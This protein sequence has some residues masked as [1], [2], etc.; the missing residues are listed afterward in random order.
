MKKFQMSMSIKSKLTAATCMLLVAFFMVVSS[1]YAW[2]TLSTAPEVTGI[3]TNI[4]ANG[5]LEMA[6]LYGE[7]TTTLTDL[8]RAV[9]TGTST[10]G[11]VTEANMTWGNLVD[12]S[13][14]S[15]GLGNIALL[16]S[17]LTPTSG[18][19]GY[20]LPEKGMIATPVY[21]A[22]GRISS[23]SNTSMTALYTAVDGGGSFDKEGYGVRGLGTSSSMTPQ[24]ADYNAAKATLKSSIASASALANKALQSYGDDLSLILIDKANGAPSNIEGLGEMIRM[25]TN[26][27]TGGNGKGVVAYLDDAVTALGRMAVAKQLEATTGYNALV[28]TSVTATAGSMTIKYTV[29]GGT[30]QTMTSDVTGALATFISLKTEIANSLS[31][32]ATAYGEVKPDADGKVKWDNGDGTGTTY[33][34]QAGNEGHKFIDPDGIT[35]AG[36]ASKDLGTDDAGTLAGY[37]ATG[38]PV[39]FTA[40]TFVDIANATDKALGTSVSMLVTVGTIVTNMPMTAIISIKKTGDAV[41]LVTF[42]NA[43]AEPATGNNASLVLTEL[44]GYVLDLA[45]R[46]NAGGSN[47]LLQT[48]PENRIYAGYQNPDENTDV[49]GGGATMTFTTA[50]P[51]VFTTSDVLNLMKA[52]RVVFTDEGNKILAIGAVQQD[53]E[54]KGYIKADASSATADN[55]AY[56]D[57]NDPNTVVADIYLYD[58]VI[59]TKTAENDGNGVAEGVLKLNG[60]KMTGEGNNATYDAKITALEKNTAKAV[61]ALVYLDGDI[62]DNSMV[63]SSGESM[64][65]KVNLQFASDATLTPMEYSPLMGE[66]T[67][68]EHT[69]EENGTVCTKCKADKNHTTHTYSTDWSS[70]G[71]NHWHASTCKNGNLNCNVKTDVAAHDTTGTDGACSV[72][73]YKAVAHEHT[74]KADWSSDATNHWHAAT[75]NEAGQ[76][77]ANQKDSIA[78]H[79]DL[80]TDDDTLC[81]VCEYDMGENANNL[82]ESTEPEN[83]GEENA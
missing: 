53:A 38:I 45:F 71:T 47:L 30:E 32:A 63:A 17:R 10:A 77:C 58:Y 62:V 49:Q 37:V 74:Y 21:G 5:N 19:D 66:Q 82:T 56:I 54:F 72:C 43:I 23:F 59:G 36:I 52:I 61:S 78:A 22:D 2:F 25:L 68:C 6:L 8:A 40:G 33:V 55:G 7:G 9:T 1:S 67:A 24:Q 69:Y 31:A 70:D 3:T 14:P 39:E 48:E 76:D 41:N 26:G 44:Y 51:A 35:V 75:C 28:I 18:E 42:G 83:G 73:G 46:T 20:T 16:P 15:Y 60:L 13:D 34:L 29:A 4:G 65:G 12:V 57:P 50:N 27:E 64:T 81:D 80:N 11:S 79:G